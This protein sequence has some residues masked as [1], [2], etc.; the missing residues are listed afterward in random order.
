MALGYGGGDGGSI[1]L[2]TQKLTIVGGG[3]VAAATFGRGNGGTVTVTAFDSLVIDAIGAVKKVLLFTT[4]IFANAQGPRSGAGG[5]ITM[6]AGNVKITDGGQIAADTFGIGPG[7]DVMVNA[8][9]L[10]IDGGGLDPFAD[11]FVRSHSSALGG[12]VAVQA[13]DVS[14][15]AGARISAATQGMGSGGNVTV[16][17]DSLLIDGQGIVDTGLFAVG[18]SSGNG[19][20]MTVEAGNVEITNAGQIGAYTTG[21]GKGGTI[22]LT[23]DSLLIDGQNQIVP[24]RSAG[25]TADAKLGNGGD[26]TVT[27]GDVKIIRGGNIST[28]TF[29]T[30][31]EGNGR[32]FGGNVTGK[33]ALA[34]H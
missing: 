18:S 34:S 19:G 17:A 13:H 6:T 26:I 10:R 12:S 32:V 5:E 9:S 4:G 8:E 1:T 29:S 16:V 15:L 23:A 20:V 2:K 21:S 30:D 7:G 27:A 22:N 28:G 3:Q 11:I 31:S 24:G 25:I 33:G 14:V